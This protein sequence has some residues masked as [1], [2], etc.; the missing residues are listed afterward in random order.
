MN[1]HIVI[2]G[3]GMV[4]SAL[5]LALGHIDGV[6]VAL[7]EAQQPPELTAD[8]PTDLRVS[9]I[10]PASQQWLDTLGIW[11]ALWPGRL[12]PFEQMQVWSGRWGQLEFDAADIGAAYLGHIVENRHIQQAALKLVQQ[13]PDITLLCPAEPVNLDNQQLELADGRRLNAD[14][15][16]AADGAQSRTREWAGLPVNTRAY[17]QQGLVCHITTRHSHQHTARQRFLK[18]GPLAFL[19]LAGRHHCSIVWSLPDDQAEYHLQQSDADFISD[20]A[21]AFELSADEV[22][23]ISE[24]RSF[25]LIEQHARQ[26]VKPG[27][28][29]VGDAAHSVHPLAGQGVNIGFRDAATLAE[30]IAWAVHRGRPAGSLHTLSKYERQRRGDNLLMQ[31]TLSAMNRLFS[32][33]LPGLA[34]VRELGLSMVNRCDLLKKNLMRQ[35]AGH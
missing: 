2:V 15:I 9:A 6:S 27:I 11:P 16:I 35:A 32:T 4:G 14:L 31:Q 24:R 22:L 1:Q 18:G 19:P 34:P 8:S 10:N 5:A 28:A 33:S 30:T 13:H 20:L 26:Y 29:L 12:G 23:E 7:V 3:G 21:R 25:P 17:H